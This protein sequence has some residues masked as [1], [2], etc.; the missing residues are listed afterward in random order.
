MTFCMENNANIYKTVILNLLSY[1]I[2]NFTP[3]TVHIN[4]KLNNTKIYITV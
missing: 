3:Y 1:K 2:F 4:F